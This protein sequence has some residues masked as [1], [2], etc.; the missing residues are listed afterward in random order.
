MLKIVLDTNVLISAA[1]HPG[2]PR[3]L[4]ASRL[5]GHFTIVASEAMFEEFTNVLKRPKFG[6]IDKKQSG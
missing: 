2:K 1:I 4:V 5:A 3:T 6:E